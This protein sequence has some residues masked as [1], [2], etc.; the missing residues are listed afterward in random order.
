[1]NQARLEMTCDILTP[2]SIWHRSLDHQGPSYLDNTSG[3]ISSTLSLFLSIKME[4][5]YF[6]IPR[7]L[8]LPQSSIF[9]IVICATASVGLENIQLLLQSSH[10]PLS[11]SGQLPQHLS[12]CR[13]TPG[14]WLAYCSSSSHHPSTLFPGS[15]IHACFWEMLSPGFLMKRPVAIWKL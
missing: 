13:Q 9:C 10:E 11:V 3:Y 5:S 4:S 1:M 7:S 2:P 12:T 6:Q 15:F 8:L 14:T